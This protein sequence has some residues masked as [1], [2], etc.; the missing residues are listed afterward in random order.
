VL[1]ETPLY[2]MVLHLDDMLYFEV[3]LTEGLHRIRVQYQAQPWVDSWGWV[4]KHSFR[5]AL[6]PAAYWKSFGSLDIQIDA[7]ACNFPLSTNIDPPQ[8][9]DLNGLA[10]WHFEELPTDLLLLKYQPK[11]SALA[12]N[13]ILLGPMGLALIG[14]IV[15]A[16][17]HLF[18]V[19]RYRRANPEKKYSWVMLLGSFLVPLFFVWL[20][21]MSYG[22]ID[23]VIG[24]QA[25]R[26]HGYVSFFI[27]FMYPLILPFYLGICWVVDWQVKKSSRTIS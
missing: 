26:Q 20:W 19:V 16:A 6:S 11:I 7:Q 18:L 27:I 4:K 5:Y 23:S 9:G 2:H 8:E 22:L 14:G 15:L 1:A 25:T 12:V 13:L 3:D 24:E 21:I 10:S 17:L